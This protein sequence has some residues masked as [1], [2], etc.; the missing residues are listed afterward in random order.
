MWDEKGDAWSL[1]PGVYATWIKV[2]FLYL[3]LFTMEKRQYVHLLRCILM[4]AKWA[5]MWYLESQS[6]HIVNNDYIGALGLVQLDS[7]SQNFHSM[8]N[9]EE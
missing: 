5:T 9:R 1:K 2:A 6:P 4:M 7:E 8:A 3:S